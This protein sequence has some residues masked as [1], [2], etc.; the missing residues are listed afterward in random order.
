MNLPEMFMKRF[1]IT[2]VV[3]LGIACAHGQY[4]YPYDS[5]NYYFDAPSLIIQKDK[6]M[7]WYVS[8]LDGRRI[9]DYYKDIRPYSQG[10]AAVNDKIMGWTFINLSSKKCTDY[11]AEVDDFHD[12]YA[13]V[14]DKEMGW[15]FIDGAGKKLISEYF[16]EAYPFH[17]G[18]ALVKDKVMGWYLLNTAGKRITDYH[19]TPWD[20]RSPTPPRRPW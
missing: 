11:F 18:V 2:F 16:D 7:G 17:H 15:T 6:V 20:F 14:K 10:Y 5:S 3:V 12:G 13:L 8:D 9:S 4:Y 1:L 19:R